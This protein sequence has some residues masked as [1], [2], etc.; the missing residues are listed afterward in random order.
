[1]KKRLNFVQIL[2]A[3]GAILVVGFH[4]RAWLNQINNQKIGD[5]LFAYGSV[6]VSIFFAISGFMVFY[7]TNKLTFSNENGF[8]IS[9]YKTSF[10]FFINRVLRFIPMYYIF[11]F[12]WIFCF[13][14]FSDYWY[15]KQL[16][17][18]IKSLLFIPD[19]NRPVLFL[20]WTLNYEVFFALFYAVILLF[21]KYK[22]H[23]FFAGIFLIFSLRF[24]T[25]NHDFMQMVVNPK[26]NYFFWGAIWAIIVRSKSAEVFFQR[27]SSVKTWAIIVFSIAII[28]VF[29]LYYFKIYVPKSSYETLLIVGLFIVMFFIW[30]FYD[31]NLKIPNFLITL[32][33]ISFM[34]YLFHPFVLMSFEK[35]FPAHFH[36]AVWQQISLFIVQ[37]LLIIF[38]SWLL[39]QYAEKKLIFKVKL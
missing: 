15:G 35:L 24:F 16:I 23:A 12:L 39:H 31:F 32:G 36:F 38:I 3:L 11:T 34:I 2:R 28:V 17:R 26:F 7:T 19:K 25:W 37:F 10:N 13:L 5:F 18:L 22:I 30:D 6:G 8:S 14:H 29:V 4:G 21:S 1:M 27:K 33:D 9:N 20:G